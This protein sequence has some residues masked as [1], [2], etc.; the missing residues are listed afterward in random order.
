MQ[1]LWAE[2]LGMCF[3]VRDALRVLG[4]IA[5]PAEVTI[6]GEL[7]HNPEVLRALDRRGFHRSP[8]AGR[9]VPATPV[10]LVTAHGISD[11][12]RARLAAAG[13]TLVDT[14]CPLV[15]TVHAAARQLAA[16]GRRVIVVGRRGHVEVRGITEDLRDPIVLEAPGEARP[17]P[18]PRLGIVCQSTTPP[19]LALEVVAA[20]RA[21]N[22]GTDVRFVDTICS[23]TRAR[24]AA[25][26]AL[27][28]HIDMLVV[29]GGAA[30][31]NTRQLALAAAARSVR[32]VHVETA[33]DLDPAT[34]AGA[35]RIGLTAGTSTLPATVDAV[36]ARLAAFAA[37][38]APTAART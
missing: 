30:S 8:E 37:A 32:A 5:R 31:N 10:V 28:P 25:V 6:H 35:E 20:V 15:R 9:G 2:E 22:P 18:E 36:A 13:K 33:A 26:Q 23:P 38:R 11:R 12:E 14:T 3:G 4:E 7:V 1:I 29:V 19:A 34:L 24:L 27:L 16:E 17:W 21:T